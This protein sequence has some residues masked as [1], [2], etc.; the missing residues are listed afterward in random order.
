MSLLSKYL[1][2]VILTSTLLVLLVLLALAVL[3][4]FI[5]QVDEVVP[6]ELRL[7]VPSYIVVGR[8]LDHA[9]KPLA[10]LQLAGQ[11]ACGGKPRTGVETTVQD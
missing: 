9:G 7:N 8:A 5:G 3:F 6:A 4:E 10:G 11:V 1:M 2:R